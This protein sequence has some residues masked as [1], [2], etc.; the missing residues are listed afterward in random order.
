[1][2]LDLLETNGT[3][4]AETEQKDS[5]RIREFP[6]NTSGASFYGIGPLRD[7]TETLLKANE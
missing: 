4:E 7:W 3:I 6:T 1:V 2:L 5:Y